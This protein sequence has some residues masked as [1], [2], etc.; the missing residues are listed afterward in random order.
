MNLFGKSRK[1]PGWLCLAVTGDRVSVSHVLTSGTAR[2]EVLLCDSFQQSGD[3]V[4]TLRKL[5]RELDL[6]RYRCMTLMPEAKYQLLQIEAPNVP[7]AEIKS[8]V[9][10]K[11]KELIDYP[12]EAAAI[13]CIS[14]PQGEGTA[15][16]TPQMFAVAAPNQQVTDFI[17]PFQDADIPLE[18]VDIP[19]LAQRN[20]AR[21][22]EEPGRGVAF[23]V[24]D[25]RGGLL[26]FTCDGELYQF[27]RLET[28]VKHFDVPD[29]EQRQ[30]LYDRITLELQRS[31]DNFDRQYQYVPIAKILVSPVPGAE[32]LKEYLAANLGLPV[33]VVNLEQI[34]EFPR[35]PE[36]RD[37]DY[38][39]SCIHL[40][41][42]AL[43]DAGA[44]P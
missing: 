41:G 26:T 17:R 39:R 7:S 38:Q 28:S 18:V 15:G 37:P 14:I 3:V 25:E 4:E 22:Y 30:Q 16:R 29:E 2:P 24:F 21:Y 27:R 23:V 36:L 10:W 34:L 31:L 32:A 13:D 9:R 1:R 44:A 43:R 6:K 33:V 12:V 11:V 19:E 8:A 5:R 40:I 42:G 35:I 20:V